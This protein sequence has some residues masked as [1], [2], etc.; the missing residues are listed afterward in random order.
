ML[1]TFN[2]L[3][4]LLA[5]TSFQLELRFKMTADNNSRFT[6]WT[7]DA[8][9]VQLRLYFIRGDVAAFPTR[10]TAAV[11]SIKLLPQHATSCLPCN[12]IILSIRAI[13]GADVKLQPCDEHN[14]KRRGISVRQV[15]LP[16]HFTFANY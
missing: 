6:V 1:L 16:V 14:E 11:R 2:L 5:G 10:N 13:V 12:P 8:S 9:S 15:S 4:L 7:R 3:L